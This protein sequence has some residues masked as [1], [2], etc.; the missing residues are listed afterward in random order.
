MQKQ[1]TIRITD[2]T[3]VAG[4]H[5]PVGSVHTLEASL[6]M[7]IISAGRAVRH[8]QSESAPD[9][10]EAAALVSPAAEQAVARPA[11]ARRRQSPGAIAE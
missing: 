10:P 8:D 4:V 1:I 11:A 5:A 2:A 6:A 3:L 7:L 9:K